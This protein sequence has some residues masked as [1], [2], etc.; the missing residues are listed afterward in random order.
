MRQGII[1]FADSAP[2]GSPAQARLLATMEALRGVAEAVPFLAYADAQHTQTLRDLVGGP[3]PR[4]FPQANRPQLGERLAQAFAFLFIQDYERVVLLTEQFEPRRAEEIQQALQALSEAACCIEERNGA[5]M[6]AVR[7]ADFP[8]VAP[9]FDEVRW[10]RPGA[11][12]EADALLAAAS[13]T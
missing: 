8:L 4:F 12:S 6:V 2:A 13:D 10:D 11:K 9:I 5:Y 1:V 7:R 3:P